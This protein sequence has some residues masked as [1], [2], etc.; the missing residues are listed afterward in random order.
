M[1]LTFKQIK[2]TK[3]SIH[4]RKLYRLSKTHKMQLGDG[5]VRD[6]Y[7][8]SDRSD[9]FTA[10]RVIILSNMSRRIIELSGNYNHVCKMCNGEG[11]II[12]PFSEEAI[13]CDKCDG[14]G[15][16]NRKGEE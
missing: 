7:I 3:Y 1:K 9:V 11:K 14:I 13:I 8:S 5:R 2:N 10:N 6:I 4:N 16:V 15:Y 12:V